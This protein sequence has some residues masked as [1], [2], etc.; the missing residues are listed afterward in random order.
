MMDVIDGKK[1]NRKGKRYFTCLEIHLKKDFKA[2]LFYHQLIGKT[3]QMIN[4]TINN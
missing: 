2:E 4:K 1:R 3:V